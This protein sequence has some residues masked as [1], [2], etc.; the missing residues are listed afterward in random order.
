MKP[1]RRPTTLRFA[2]ALAGAASAA[3]MAGLPERAA[4]MQVDGAPPGLNLP[5]TLET[6]VS[7]AVRAHGQTPVLRTDDSRLES[8]VKGNETSGCNREHRASYSRAEARAEKVRVEDLSIQVRLRVRSY[9]Q[10]GFYRTCLGV[11]ARDTDGSSNSEAKATIAL[12]LPVDLVGKPIILNLQSSSAEGLHLDVVGPNGVAVPPV[13][14]QAGRYVVSSRPGETIFIKAELRAAAVSSGGGGDIDDRKSALFTAS[15]EPGPMLYSNKLKPF[16]KGGTVTSS[17]K[18]VGAIRLDG[19]PHC[20]GTLV[21]PQTVLTAAHCVAGYARQIRDGRFTFATGASAFAPDRVFKV[22]TGDYPKDETGGFFYNPESYEDD[23]GI[24][25]LDF[26][27]D[28]PLVNI[29][30]GLPDWT[31]LKA[32]PILFV[33]YGY[34]VIDG[35]MVGAG[36]KREAVWKID[37]VD[38][39]T[40]AWVNPN[41]S[42]CSGDSGGPALYT[43]ASAFLV[44][45]I[46]SAGDATCTEGRNTRVDAYLAWLNGRLR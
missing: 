28:L 39:R 30:S 8:E 24:L 22:A 20:T 9:S 46:T 15:I 44:V 11:T 32:L 16:I 3:G 14:G 27:T 6:E 12:R 29:H 13:T 42:T 23:I 5:F 21:A 37:R 10:G 25:Y 4:A 34:N 26:P 35:G 41:T 36:I 2:V 7:V 33:G 31:T 43:Q 17:Y 18:Q 40:I 1:G 19:L 38:N 45:A